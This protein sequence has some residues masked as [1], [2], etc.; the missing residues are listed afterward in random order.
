MSAMPLTVFAPL[1]RAQ[2]TSD[3]A[4]GVDRAVSCGA[5][6]AQPATARIDPRKKAAG[7]IGRVFPFQR[8]HESRSRA[9]RGPVF[10]WWFVPPSCALRDLPSSMSNEAAERAHDA[11]QPR[12]QTR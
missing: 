5:N 7:F 12:G 10:L 11:R 6:W 8:E 2:S 1:P 3:G 4:I 9:R